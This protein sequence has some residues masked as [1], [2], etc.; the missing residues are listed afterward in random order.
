[1]SPLVILVVWGSQINLG[2]LLGNESSVGSAA[3]WLSVSP[4][5]LTEA[6]MFC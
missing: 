6:E 2:I 1:M 5:W 3:S 4:L